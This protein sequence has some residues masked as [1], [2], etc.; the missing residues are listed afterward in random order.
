MFSH[1][2]C[3]VSGFSAEM[4]IGRE[5]ASMPSIPCAQTSEG[6]LVEDIDQAQPSS[7]AAFLGLQFLDKGDEPHLIRCVARG[8]LNG[9]CLP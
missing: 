2:L 9:Q 6:N 8:L 1:D 5:E 7:Y 4:W 3:F